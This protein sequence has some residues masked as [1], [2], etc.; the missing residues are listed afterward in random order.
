MKRFNENLKKDFKLGSILC[1][2]FSFFGVNIFSRKNEIN[3]SIQGVYDC[4]YMC[5]R[6]ERAKINMA[7]S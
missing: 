3:V 5:M 1:R 6:G 4:I 7:A 2:Y